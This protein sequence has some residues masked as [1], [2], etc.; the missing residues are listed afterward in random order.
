MLSFCVNFEKFHNTFPT[1]FLQAVMRYETFYKC[2]NDRCDIKAAY[3]QAKAKKCNYRC[4]SCMSRLNE[5]ELLY[6]E[7]RLGT[8]FEQYR[9]RVM[10][11]VS[12]LYGSFFC[13]FS[14]PNFGG[15]IDNI[16]V[17]YATA[18][19]LFFVMIVG[20]YSRTLGEYEKEAKVVENNLRPLNAALTSCGLTFF[21]AMTFLFIKYPSP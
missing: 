18:S 2:G 6:I 17:R 19:L 4:L 13:Y 14:P 5:C 1:N 12:L 7:S 10:A 16:F 3:N 9:Y 8:W 21:I 15:A 20:C 11:L